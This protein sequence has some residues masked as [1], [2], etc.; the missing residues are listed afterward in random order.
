MGDAAPRSVYM[1]SLPLEFVTVLVGSALAGFLIGTLQHYVSFGIWGYP[2]NFRATK[3]DN[4]S[5]KTGGE[6]LA[7]WHGRGICIL[8][9]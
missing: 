9:V 7:E 4:S 5:Q 3:L 6:N 8:C 2:F 1:R